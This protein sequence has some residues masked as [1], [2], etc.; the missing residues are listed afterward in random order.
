MK[1]FVISTGLS[2]SI[3]FILYF[4][5]ADLMYVDCM[6]YCA[7]IICEIF[8]QSHEFSTPQRLC[9]K[10]IL[11]IV[12]VQSYSPLCLTC[13]L[14]IHLH[15]SYNVLDKLIPYICLVMRYGLVMVLLISND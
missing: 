1:L 3:I 5:C 10:H 12:N 8:V 2:L 7:C 11:Y 15:C 9:C 4:V 6:Q 14:N 13:D